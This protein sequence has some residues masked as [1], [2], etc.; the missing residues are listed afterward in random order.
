M[1]PRQWLR[2]P[3]ILLAFAATM[4]MA[5]DTRTIRLV[6]PFPAGGATDAIARMIASKLAQSFG[7]P[8]IVDNRTGASGQIG[9]AYVKSA[10]PDGLTYL[11]TPDHTIV[12]L[13]VLMDSAGYDPLKDFTAVGQVARFQLALSTSASG[14]VTNLSGFKEW[15]RAHPDRANFGVP[16]VGGYPSMVGVA[17]QKSIGVPM[18]AV[19]YRGSGPVVTDVAGGQVAAGVTG[20]ADV[21]PMAQGGRA[22]ILAVTGR[23][24]SSMVPDV[25]T[26]EEL[27]VPGLTVDSW[28]AFFAPAGLPTATAE[29]FNRALAKA[30]AEQ[31]IQQKI[32]ELSIELAP[33]SLKEADDLLKG[34]ARY[35]LDASKQP[36]FVRP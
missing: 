30:L 32:A 31:D 12:T 15:A 23:Q 1:N 24:R 18:T 4:A 19:P 9:T 33:T 25:P 7:Q 34:A 29:R 10:P 27:G 13:P 26:F 6:V 2:L 28:Y 21:L 36:D 5:Q 16:V 14:G 22:R 20:L 35:W 11:F 3:L 8:V 17:L